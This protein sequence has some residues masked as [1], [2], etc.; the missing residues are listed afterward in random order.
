MGE[1]RVFVV[2]LDGATLDLVG[3]WAEQAYLPTL[4][5]MMHRGV[6][7]PLLST[8]PP[9]TGPAWSSFMTGKSPGR[10]G[11]LEFFRREEGSY[12]QV[13]STRHDIAG[14]SLWRLL[15]DAGLMVGI[16][17]VPLTYPPEPINGFVVTGLLTPP[18]RRDFTYP[19]GLLREL[20][21]Q[22]G[23]YRLRHDAKYRKTDPQPFLHE[24][25]DILENNAQA[26][27]YLMTHKPWDFFMVHFLGT[28]RIQHE[29]WHLLD[30]RH[31]Q[32]D[33]AE[34]QRLGNVVLDF[35]RQVDATL[36][37]L[38]A[39]LDDETVV[40]IMSDHGFGPVHKFVNFNTW[41]LQQR[42]LRLKTTVGTRLRYALFRAG[43]NYSLLGRTVLRLGW[44]QRAKA[45]GRARREE[46]QRRCFL[47]LDDVDWSRSRVYSI[48][49][50]G[51]LYVNLRGR[52]PQ[53]IVSPGSEY[54]HVLD[55]L[56]ERLQAMV[57]PET[58]Q[59]IIELIFRRE[60]AYG[61]PYADHSPDLM[62]LTRN[63]EYKAM[64][65]SDFSS[66][67]VVEPVYGTTGHHRM[68][69]LLVCHGPGAV[70]EGEWLEGAR[71]QDLAPTILYAMGQS[72]PRE[73]DGQVLLDLFT[74]E[75]RQEHAV[76]Y[77][78]D[79]QSPPGES[80]SVYTLEEEGEIMEMLRSLGYAS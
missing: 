35:F 72:I 76:T 60:Q 77:A 80:P 57:D 32:H 21:A 13:L 66:P 2:G 55:D 22:L 4:R 39:A 47:S 25:F 67:R 8:F 38:L 1:H 24:Q 27:L 15:A 63:M 62:F 19:L 46:L 30:P 41:L 73:M 59:P 52:E 29:F 3:P 49:S 14:R 54:E 69:G 36:G 31:P 20:E 10:H 17:G 44:G 18:G 79:S 12:R 71:I 26:A 78:Q 42:L 64:G 28:D 9:L 40:I 61:G 11:V 50:F 70:R 51:Q 16:L 45:M 53:G 7:G 5:Q 48:G 56:T 37:R 75:F 43:L 65:L 74:H 23:R 33:V 58:G 68:N 34:R 6:S